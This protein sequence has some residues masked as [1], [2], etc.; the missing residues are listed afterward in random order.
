MRI[1]ILSYQGFIAG[2]TFSIVYLAKGLAERGHEI[3][4]GCKKNEMLYDLLQDSNVNVVN[5]P[6][7]SKVDWESIRIVK[8]LVKNKKIDIINAQASN[9]RYVSMLVKKLFYADLKVVHTRRQ[10]PNSSGGYLHG[11]LYSW[12]TDKIVAVSKG[13]KNEAMK[14]MGIA[15]DHLEVIHNGTPSEKYQQVLND[16]AYDL[17]DKYNIKKNDW[18]IG[19]VSRHKKQEQLINALKF[20][21]SISFKVIFVGIE[22]EEIELND[23]QYPEH[24]EFIFTGRIPPDEALRYYKVFDIHVLPSS[25]EGL[26]QSLLEAMFLK[27]PVIA[28]DAMGNPDLIIHNQTGFLFQDGNVKELAAYI[29]KLFHNDNIYNSMVKEAKKRVE[30]HFSIP[31]VVDEYER[32]FQRL[33][34]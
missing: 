22:K 25:T 21:K 33:I 10:R 1:L 5:V 30:D 23:T 6:Y 27:V 13:V 7:K 17:K 31:R 16:K 32:F 15:E 2:S 18:V 29:N 14:R 26:S 19:C 9:D 12:G 28:T 20:I 4:V 34:K 24:H 3:Y 8:D 11:K